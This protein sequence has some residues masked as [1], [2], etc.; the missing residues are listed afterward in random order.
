MLEVTNGR[1][2][3]SPR[4]SRRLLFRNDRVAGVDMR[5][6]SGRRFRAILREVIAEFGDA[7]LARAAEIA[8]LRQLSEAAQTAIL[9]GEADSTKEVVRLAN[10][11]ARI[12]RE[13]RN[14]AGCAAQP[15]SRLDAMLS[16]MA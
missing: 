14:T 10:V 12:E 16:G 5:T 15:P 13:L 6:R 11:L 8:R 7:D 9:N 2:E 3:G 4:R 1:K